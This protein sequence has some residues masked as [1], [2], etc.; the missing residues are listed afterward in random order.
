MA[1]VEKLIDGALARALEAG[2]DRFNALFAQ[3]RHT[4]RGLDARAFG[5]FLRDVV[6]PAVEALARVAPERVQATVEVLYEFALE[7]VGR[8]LPGRFPVLAEGWRALLGGL[9]RHLAQAPRR[10]AGSVTNALHNLAL[11]PGTRPAEW[12]ETVRRVGEVC[13]DTAALLEAGQ[14]AAWRAGLAHYREGALEVGARLDPVVACAALGLPDGAP[15]AQVLQ[16][17]RA[18]PW[19]SPEAAM[20]ATRARALGVVA[21]VGDFRGFGGPFL[22]PPRVACVE[23]RFLVGDGEGCWIL[24]ADR[25][26]ATFHR[27]AE[28]LPATG[29]KPRDNFRIDGRGRV[30]Y[31]KQSVTLDELQE[32]AS[33]AT[34][35][36]TLAVTLPL[37]HRV[38][39]IAAKA[40]L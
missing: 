36:A 14:V 35:G 7:L 38:Y 30:M 39:L 2:R 40:A 25:F 15:V 20:S 32:C 27:T 13:P 11:V 16:R 21:R 28:E 17:L 3:A 10:F 1:E 9:T 29:G 19:L 18:D 23:G 5:E 8:E 31:G 26:G 4:L 6:G 33:Q 34:D 22:R 24:T 12:I 37:S